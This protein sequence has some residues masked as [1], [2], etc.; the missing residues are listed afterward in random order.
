MVG[1]RHQR[2]WAMKEALLREPK[3]EE[4]A[5]AE[6]NQRAAQARVNSLQSARA[7]ADSGAADK[8]IDEARIHASATVAI[9]QRVTELIQ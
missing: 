5:Q 8:R 3:A 9:D 2:V 6:A 7:S 1:R 4:V